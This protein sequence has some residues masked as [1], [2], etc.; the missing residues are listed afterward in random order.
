MAGAGDAPGHQHHEEDP[1]V[2]HA[3]AGVLGDAGQALGL[4]GPSKASGK[5]MIAGVASE[6]AEDLAYL[7]RLAETG[8]FTP[9][10]DRSYPLESAAEAHAY[11]DT[12]RKRGNVVLTVARRKEDALVAA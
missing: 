2:H 7:A 12:G 6:R 3:R 11:V 8:E 10:I 4:G 9:V 1:E 5:R